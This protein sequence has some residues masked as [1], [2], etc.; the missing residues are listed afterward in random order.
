[1]SLISTEDWL[2]DTAFTPFH[3]AEHGRFASMEG[4]RGWIETG[5]HQ[6]DWR[7]LHGMSAFIR[8]IRSATIPFDDVE[9]HD[10]TMEGYLSKLMV[11]QWV[12]PVLE[13]YPTAH[14]YWKEIQQAMQLVRQRDY[15]HL[16]DW[17]YNPL[18]YECFE[19]VVITLLPT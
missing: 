9:L 19:S 15:D 6:E 8:R 13:H 11:G 12:V 7:H 2:R 14:P 5:R 1:M 3:H 16:P 18:I 4:F 17:Y 10:L